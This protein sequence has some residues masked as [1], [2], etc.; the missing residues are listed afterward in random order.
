MAE[1]ICSII[2]AVRREQTDPE[3]SGLVNSYL[4]IVE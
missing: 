1:E 4:D 3:R 2:T